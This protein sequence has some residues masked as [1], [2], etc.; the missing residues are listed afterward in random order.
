MDH[1]QM[2][3]FD[4]L[5]EQH[6]LCLVVCC[7]YAISRVFNVS[8]PLQRVTEAVLSAIPTTSP[9]I[10]AEAVIKTSTKSAGQ[11]IP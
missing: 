10:F 9:N 5:F 3:H 8:V 4:L 11:S 7:V 1:L 2:V 6:Q